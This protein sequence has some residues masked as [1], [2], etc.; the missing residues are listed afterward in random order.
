M[1]ALI[2]AALLALALWTP[3][4]DRATLEARYLASPS[5][6]VEVAGMRLDVRDRGPRDAPTAVLI[7]GF[8]SSLETWDAWADALEAT[9]R[10]VR[11]DLP[12]SGLSDADPTGDYSDPRTVE[13]MVALFDRLGIERASVIGHSIGGRIAWTFAAGHP[14]RVDRLVL[15]S[16]DGFASPGLGYGESPKVG[17]VGNA[18]RFVM[19]RPLVRSVL[20]RAFGDPTKL[21]DALLTRYDDLLRAPGARQRWLMRWTQGVRVDPVPRLKTITAP[22]LLLWGTA[23]A[24]I[25]F[26]NA[27]DYMAA[28]PHATLVPLPG[29]GH[30]PQEEAPDASLAIVASF[31]EP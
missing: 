24:A 15:I 6:L 16:P 7:H 20:A 21:T 3:D 8:A 22:T 13:V 17:A 11:F 5:D 26:A 28:L 12:G 27:A 10:V 14:E 30:V 9:H 23:D 2:L 25:P 31:L 1:I 19:P 4:L 18:L 29:V